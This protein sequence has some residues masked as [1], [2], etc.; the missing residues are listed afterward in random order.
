VGV[1][2]GRLP[3]AI[4]Q[5]RERTIAIPVPEDPGA[6]LGALLALADG[7]GTARTAPTAAEAAS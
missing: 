5:W 7:L 3:E 1:L 4:Y 6:R 2:N